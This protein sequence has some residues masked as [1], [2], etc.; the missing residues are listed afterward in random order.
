MWVEGRHTVAHFILGNF[1]SEG[2]EGLSSEAYT[3]TNDILT[4]WLN[5]VMLDLK[6][7]EIVTIVTITYKNLVT[8]DLLRH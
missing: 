2:E 1:C 6:N 3:T 7:L 8:E 4:S 5:Q